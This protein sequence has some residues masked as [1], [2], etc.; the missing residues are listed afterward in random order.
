[1]ADSVAALCQQLSQGLGQLTT[2][3]NQLM[4]TPAAATAQQALPEPDQWLGKIT[5]E[6]SPAPP[7]VLPAAHQRNVLSELTGSYSNTMLNDSGGG[8]GTDPFD[9]EWVRN[10]SARTT[11]APA[12]TNP[13]LSNDDSI[14]GA[15]SSAHQTFQVQL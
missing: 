7:P 14:V 13:F 1:M 12:P 10:S 11:P 15:T 4:S 8:V 3:H 2:R 6:V 9:S 5:A